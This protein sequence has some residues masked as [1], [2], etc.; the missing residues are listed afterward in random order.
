LALPIPSSLKQHNSSEANTASFIRQKKENYKGYSTWSTGWSWS[1]CPDLMRW[2]A[3]FDHFRILSD[4][5]STHCFRNTVSNKKETR[6]KSETCHLNSTVTV[7][8]MR[9]PK[10][11]LS[12]LTVWHVDWYGLLQIHI[13]QT[14]PSSTDIN[15][16]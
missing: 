2:P 5:G 4:D 11:R 16:N 14:L 13:N 8:S 10:C 15:K 3:E 12:P 1:P 6:Q 9:R 7:T